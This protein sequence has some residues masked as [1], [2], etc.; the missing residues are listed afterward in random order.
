MNGSSCEKEIEC[1]EDDE[2]EDDDHYDD[3]DDNDDDY[4]DH[5]DYSLLGAARLYH[6]A[7]IP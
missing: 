4:N 5:H 3:H 6:M 2:D 1:D 7:W